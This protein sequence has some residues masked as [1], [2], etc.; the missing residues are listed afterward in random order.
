MKN[1]LTQRKSHFEFGENWISF[2][3]RISDER[4]AEAVYGLERLFP[5]G[6]LRGKRFLDIGCGS[7][8]SMLA[9]LKLGA[10]EVIGV[11]ID[12][13]SVEATH[14]CMERFAPGE[15]WG[16]EQAS[17][18]ELDGARMGRFDVVYSWGVLHHTGDMWRAVDTAAAMVC[19]GGMLAIALYRKTRFC[20]FWRREKYFYSHLPRLLQLPVCWLYQGA[21]L[22]AKLAI[23]QNPITFV[24]GYQGNRGMSWTHDVHDWLGGYPYQSA[25]PEEV[26]RYLSNAGFRVVRERIRR[27]HG[28]G[29]FG[30]S[31]D[32]YV[33]ARKQ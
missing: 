23:R 10:R 7:G 33:F 21:F 30:S 9:A 13:N 31:C 25:S 27:A 16:V 22:V 4:I 6:E 3:N 2:L 24:R 8:L 5:D 15:A 28:L 18:F 29:L 26:R 19:D 17:V 20:G 11:D 14:R 1:D 32:E 12:E